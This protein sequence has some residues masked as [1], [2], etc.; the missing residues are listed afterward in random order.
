MVDS[1]FSCLKKAAALNCNGDSA[2][3]IYIRH[4]LAQLF[5]LGHDHDSAWVYIQSP[6]KFRDYVD[7][8]AVYSIMVA[9]CMKTNRID[10]AALLCG[11]LLEMGVFACQAFC[12][13]NS[14]WYC[15]AKITI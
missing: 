2:I 7:K 8:S 14:C 11:E 13:K 15:F 1:A 12:C 5:L 3:T 6:P 9:I 4:R 10:S